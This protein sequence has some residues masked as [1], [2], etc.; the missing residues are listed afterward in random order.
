MPRAIL[1]VFLAITV[2]LPAC[3]GRQ[4]QPESRG[5]GDEPKWA[6]DVPDG[7]GVGTVEYRGNRSL[8]RNASNARA[9][10][11]LARQL[12]T[13]IQGMLSDYVA[14]GEVDG[15]DFTE[16]RIVQVSRQVVDTTL[17]GTVPVATYVTRGDSQQMYS[18][19]CIKPDALAEAIAGMQGLSDRQRQLLQERA[20]H[21]YRQLDQVLGQIQEEDQ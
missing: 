19:V 14:Q 10:D 12:E 11:D 20:E 3:G 16:E 13:S 15:R 2:L 8:A 9:R 18:L 6:L 4:P 7:C 5:F 1:A 17:V 21:E